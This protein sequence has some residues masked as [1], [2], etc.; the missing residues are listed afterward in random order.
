MYDCSLK[1]LRVRSS[2]QIIRIETHRRKISD[3]KNI[4]KTLKNTY[5]ALKNAVGGNSLGPW[6]CALVVAGEVL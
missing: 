2:K 3:L 5:K 1:V 4:E 6:S